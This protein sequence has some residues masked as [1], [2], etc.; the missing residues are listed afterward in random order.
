[1]TSLK[2]EK[3]AS[4]NDNLNL[5]NPIEMNI[6]A[7]DWRTTAADQKEIGVLSKMDE[8]FKANGTLINTK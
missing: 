4:T 1:M 5:T 8:I 2:I 6:K 7:M 3:A